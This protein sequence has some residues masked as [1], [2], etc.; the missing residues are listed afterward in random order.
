MA[1]IPFIQLLAVLWSSP[2]AAD[3]TS[4]SGGVTLSQY[5]EE[6]FVSL[7]VEGYL[8]KTQLEDDL[9]AIEEQLTDDFGGQYQAGDDSSW[10]TYTESPNA[11]L[12][13][14]G[15]KAPE[16]RPSRTYVEVWNGGPSQFTTHK[17]MPKPG[18][19]HGSDMPQA[20]T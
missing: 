5:V 18:P 3:Q 1:R 17:A 10:V 16:A 12:Q 9:R 14:V 7:T 8:T 13:A 4:R 2:W 11:V 6:G 20:G 15:D 19:L